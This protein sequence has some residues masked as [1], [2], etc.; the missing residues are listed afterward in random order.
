MVGGLAFTIPS[1]S[2]ARGRIYSLGPAI[3]FTEQ[4]PVPADSAPILRYDPWTRITDTAA[5]LALPKNN[6]SISSRGAGEVSFRAGGLQPYTPADEWTV[7]SDG[8]IVI[9]RVSD[10]HVEIV[11]PGGRRIVGPKVTYTPVRVGEAEKE[12]WRNSQRTGTRIAVTAEVGSGGANRSVSTPAAPQNVPEPAAWPATKPP[13]GASGRASS[14][15]AAPNGETWI[16]RNRAANDKIPT[17][18]VFDG[19]GR[20][21]GRMVFPADTRLV[22][23]GLKGAYLVRTDADDLQYLQRYGIQWTG[24]PPEIKEVCTGR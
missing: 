2:D 17:A 11:H 7:L 4:G 10:Y 19:Q 23:L 12:Q 16:V 6:V 15:F 3:A 21:V 22:T 5:F 18:D 1:T 24:C 20:L 14:L 9:A 13:F 8:R